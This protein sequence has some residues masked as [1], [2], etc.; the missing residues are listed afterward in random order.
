M[1]GTS[2][3]SLASMSSAPGPTGFQWQWRS[4]SLHGV[5]Y[6]Y[7]SFD[8]TSRPGT[9]TDASVSGAQ[10][11]LPRN[12][13]EGGTATPLVL[14]VVQHPAMDVARERHPAPVSN[15]GALTPHTSLTTIR[16][17]FETMDGTWR[18]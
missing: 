8:P 1:L 16:Q 3:H 17:G 18:G 11:P 13:P 9:F 7:I 2:P 4:D 14:K 6:R 15:S 10:R 5:Y 12:V